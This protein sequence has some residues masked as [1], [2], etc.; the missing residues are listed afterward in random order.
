VPNIAS[1][2][3]KSIEYFRSDPLVGLFLLLEDLDPKPDPPKKES[4]ISPN[5]P[6]SSTPPNPEPAPPLPLRPA[7]P[8]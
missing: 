2:K 7:C 6:K 8:N 1:S 5:P 3:S 4:N